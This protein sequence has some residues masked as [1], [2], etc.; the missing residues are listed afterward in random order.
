VGITISFGRQQQAKRFTDYLLKV[1]ANS[2]SY[3]K[4]PQ[5]VCCL[6][7]GG[8]EE[9]ASVRAVCDL[10]VLQMIVPLFLRL[11]CNFSFS[12]LNNSWRLF[13]KPFFDTLLEDLTFL[14]KSGLNKFPLNLLQTF[15]HRP[16]KSPPKFTSRVS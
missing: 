3:P 10:F 7:Y 4:T 15:L 6:N 11:S 9:R 8:R 12:S 14:D 13:F 5:S 2:R 1:S 16:Q